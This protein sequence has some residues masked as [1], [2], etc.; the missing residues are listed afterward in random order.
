[1]RLGNNVRVF[2]EARRESVR[3]C[4]AAIGWDAASLS[5]AER[6]VR[7]FPDHIKIALAQHFGVSVTRLFFQDD[8]DSKSPTQAVA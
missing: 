8:G 2:R 5:K 1:M 7:G 3:V 4:A 6:G